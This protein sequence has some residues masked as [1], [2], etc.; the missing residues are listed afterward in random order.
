MMLQETLIAALTCPDGFKYNLHMCN[1]L[2]ATSGSACVPNGLPEALLAPNQ[3]CQS[4]EGTV[5]AT[6][7]DR[8]YS[9]FNIF[10]QFSLNVMQL[11]Q[12]IVR[13]IMLSGKY[14]K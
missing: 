8:W 10:S 12:L 4:T 6:L 13:C 1:Y 3:Q 5:C 14:G 11:M 2:M 7:K 9:L